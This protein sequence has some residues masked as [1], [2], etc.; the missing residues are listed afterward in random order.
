M[1]RR[2]GSGHIEPARLEKEYKPVLED[3]QEKDSRFA[4]W[5]L[6]E[7]ESDLYILESSKKAGN[8]S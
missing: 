4:K 7:Q 8:V 6:I 5:D 3:K 1:L 2:A